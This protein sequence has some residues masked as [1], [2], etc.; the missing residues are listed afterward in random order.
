MDSQ[1]DRLGMLNREIS[2]LEMESLLHRIDDFNVFFTSMKEKY[3]HQSA[4]YDEKN[5]I[6]HMM[7]KKLKSIN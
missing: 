4:T 1:E 2:V 6:F 7:F 5:K 3:R